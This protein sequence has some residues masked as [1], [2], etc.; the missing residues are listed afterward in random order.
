MANRKIAFVGSIGCG[1]TVLLTVLTHR[2][3][4]RTEEGCQICPDNQEASNFCNEKWEALSN[5]YW[6]APTPPANKPPIYRWKLC[7]GLK[8]MSLVTSDIAGEAWRSFITESVEADSMITTRSPWESVKQ[9]WNNLKA[10][11]SQESI[12]EHITTVKNLLEEASGIFLLLD[13]S[14]IIDKEPGYELSMFLPT[15]LVKHMKNIRRKHVPIIL[16]L[17]KAAKYKYKYEELGDWQKVLKSCIPWVPAFERIIPVSAV[18][19]TKMK[20]E[21]G[22]EKSVPAKDFGSEG[23]KELYE[24][25][26]GNMAGAGRNELKQTLIRFCKIDIPVIVALYLVYILTFVFSSSPTVCWTFLWL[27]I[28]GYVGIKGF[29]YMRK[30]R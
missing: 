6:P 3:L 1:K 27:A 10:E 20:T 4:E 13:L 30:P 2:F 12:G 23:I 17:S 21:N 28:L 15:A 22:E 25:I 14:Q 8:E 24:N 11:L 26:W 29:L 5:G 19:N 16:V 7:N 9:Q 18:V